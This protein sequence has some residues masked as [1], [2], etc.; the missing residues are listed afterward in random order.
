M[1]E[2]CIQLLHFSVVLLVIYGNTTAVGV[3]SEAKIRCME[4]E[5]QAL[6][7]FKEVVVDDYGV[8]LSWGSEEYK[9]DCCKWR[10]VRCNKSTGH[11]TKIDLHISFFAQR[12]TG[13]ISPSLLELQHLK[14][15]NLGGNDFGGN[16][17]PVFIA[18]FSRLQ[19]LDLWGNSFHGPIPHQLGNLSSLRYLDLSENQLDGGNIEWLSHLS[20][21][22][23]LDLSVVDLS[24]ATNWTETINSLPFLKNLHLRHCQLSNVVPF[25]S[26]LSLEVLDLSDNDLSSS[27]YS[28]LFNLSNGLV[29]VYLSSNQLKGL[30]PDSFGNMISLVNLDL[31]L[32]QLEGGIPKSFSNLTH[33]QTLILHH[34][35]LNGTVTKSIGQL[36]KLEYLDLSSNN[37]KGMISE[38]HFSN[39]STLNYLDLSFNSLALNISSDWIPPFQFGAILLSSCKLGPYFPKWLHNQSNFLELDISGAGIS[40]VVPAWFWDLPHKLRY[41]NLSYNQMNGLLPDLSLKIS[42]DLEID[43]SSNCFTGHVPRVPS[44]VTFLSLSKNMFS[45]SIYFI[46]TS[47]GVQLIYLDLSNNQLS[48]GL[49]DCWEKFEYLHII[50]LANNNLSGKLPNSMGSLNNLQ[51]LLLRNNSFHGELPTSLKNCEKVI[52]IDLGRNRFTGEIQAWIGMHLTSLI[53][54][55]LRA[56]KFYGGIPE[57]ICHLNHIQVL[58]FSQNDLLGELPK[59]FNNFSSLVK[60]DGFEAPYHLWYQKSHGLYTVKQ[61]YGGNA[62]LQWKG[63]EREYTKNLRLLKI[64]DLSSNK[65]CG[66]VPKQ[67]ATLA[68]LVSLNLSRNNLTGQIIQEIGQMKMLESLDLSGNRL[69]SEIPTSLTRLNYLS[70]LDL[71]N[72]NLS[73]KIPS[74][75]QL[76]SFNASAYS[77]NPQ[78]CGL[79]LANKCPREEIVVKPP[80]KDTRSQEEEEEDR[81]ITAW[82]YISMGFGFAVGFVVVFGTILFSSSSGHAYFQFL[83]RIHNW[84][85][86]AAP[87]GMRTCAEV[88]VDQV[89]YPIPAMPVFSNSFLKGITAQFFMC[90]LLWMKCVLKDCN[91]LFWIT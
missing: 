12:L 9:R 7:Q 48:G 49:P 45:G 86:A 22:R 57:T 79:P 30:I 33:L 64:I 26:S 60:N 76:Q 47:I 83:D 71:S 62:L 82:F 67:V 66:K 50:N 88:E 73:G 34:N 59:C 13:K 46:C 8:L 54:L 38:E 25:N 63:Q 15:L 51:A 31:S 91:M 1:E 65:F 10:G 78:L 74:G 42:G 56:N 61:F 21:L 20:L 23:H 35:S 75:T 90:N 43:L 37:L 14:Y 11:V 29:D 16:Q 72:N 81:F 2:K 36:S 40:D 77:G 17:I 39:L 3:S 5:K 68:G 80:G 44:N 87:E 41:L 24:Q 69:S 27:I 89:E 4:R 58:D 53:V 84:L 70:L 32:N 18:S 55:S 85:E 28:W 6:L 19:Y 52:Y